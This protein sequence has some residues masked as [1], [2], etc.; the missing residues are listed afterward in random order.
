MA[1]KG[2]AAARHLNQTTL[3]GQWESHFSG[4]D[5]GRAARAHEIIQSETAHSEVLFAHQQVIPVLQCLIF[6]AAVASL[7]A[8]KVFQSV[9]LRCDGWLLVM[10]KKV[11]QGWEQIFL[12]S[13]TGPLQA[14]AYLLAVKEDVVDEPPATAFSGPILD[15]VDEQVAQLVHGEQGVLDE[16][17]GGKGLLELGRPS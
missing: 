6:V 15:A 3:Q 8:A 14:E 4:W 9:D 16:Q 2:E 17:D 1:W 13:E 11:G 7:L 12:A 10:D 5:D